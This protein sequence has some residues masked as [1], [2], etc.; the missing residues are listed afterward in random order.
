M[1]HTISHVEISGADPNKLREFY[2]QVFDWQIQA[3]P[4]MNYNM[5]NAEAPQPTIGIGSS[6][7]TPYVTFYVAVPD[8]QATL[9]QVKKLGGTVMM[10]P[11]EIPGYVTMAMF[12]DP[13]GHIIG[14]TK[15]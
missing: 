6:P 15:G 9:D 5:V 1:P 14:L 3:I 13:E 12:S 4:E 11:T 10:E 8:L 7:E 2:G